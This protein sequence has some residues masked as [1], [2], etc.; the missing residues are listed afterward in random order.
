MDDVPANRITSSAKRELD[1]LKRVSHPS[2]TRL[3]AYKELPEKCLF[4]LHFS[5]GGDLFDFASRNRGLLTPP[6]VK[7]IFKELALAVQYLHT[8]MHVVH[9]DLKL[10]SASPKTPPIANRRH[11]LKLPLHRI[12][13]SGGLSLPTHRPHRLR[14]L[15]PLRPLL[16]PPHHPLRLNRLR[17]SR[18]HPR[19]A[20]RRPL[21]RRLGPGRHPLLSPRIP[22]PV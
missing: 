7:R 21:H 4:A 14:P 6:L 12:I 11:P 18:N 9:R 16:P 17:R 19:T 5:P 10:E 13:R 15:P 2:I 1:I 8:E 22:S 3:L 20:L